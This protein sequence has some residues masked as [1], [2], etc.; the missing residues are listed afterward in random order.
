VFAFDHR[1]SN[2]G[3]VLVVAADLV[4][5][6]RSGL[7]H[8]YQASLQTGSRTISTATETKA[9]ILQHVATVLLSC[10][11][12]YRF[13][14]TICVSVKKHPLFLKKNN[15]RKAL[16]IIIIPYSLCYFLFFHQ[17]QISL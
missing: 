9:T 7:C 1:D 2:Q 12:N 8:K 6:L 15:N 13:A 10:W 14:E 16:G 4:H 17:M 11:Q 5:P 3:R